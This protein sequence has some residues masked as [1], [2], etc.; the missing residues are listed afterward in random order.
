MEFRFDASQ[1]YQL[2][3]IEAVA[4]LLNGQPRHESTLALAAGTGLA[5]VANRFDL[6]EQRL[7]ENLQAVQSR[8][9]IPRSAT[10]ESIRERI[11]T[12]E[13]ESD[14]AFPNFSVEM[15]TGTGKTYVYLRTALELYQRYGLR[16]FIVVVPSVAVREGVLKTLQVTERHLREL[17]GN[18]PYRYYVYDSAQLA[19]VRQFALSDGVEIMIMT[20]DAFARAENVIRQSTD[21]LQGET[22]IHLVQLARPVLIL[23]EPQNMESERRVAALASLHPLF[24]LRYSATHRNAYN[25]VYRLTPAEAYRQGLVKRIQV[26]GVVQDD[27]PN[28]AFVR[29]DS[30]EL[31]RGAPKAGLTIHKLRADG[32]VAPASVTVQRE[33]KL[34]E[35]SGGRPQY[36]GYEVEEIN[37][38]SGYVRFANNVELRVGDVRGADREAV[39]D[40]QIRWTVAEHLRQQ[41]RLRDRGIKV[42]SLLFI[43]QVAS[44]ADEDGIVRTLF[45]RAFD[46]LKQPYEHWRGRDARDVRA[47]YFAEKRRRDGSVEL[48]D[49]T[50]G[51]NEQDR[52]AYDLIMKRKEQLLSFDEPAAFIFSHSALREGWDNPNVF[53]ICTLAQ[54]ASETKKRQE[55]GRGMRLAVDQTGSRVPDERVNVLT[56]VPN[57]SYRDYVSGLQD[58]I[59]E[60]YGDE[61]TPPPPPN[62]RERRPTVLRKG[63]T[64]RPEF[65]ELWQKISRRTRYRVRIDTERLLAEAVP[66]VERLDVRPPAVTVTL[67]ALQMDARSE[68]QAVQL[69][70]TRRVADLAPPQSVPNLVDIVLSLLERA[71]PPV[72]LTRRTIATLFG[73]IANK[74][75]ALANPHDF[76]AG[77]ARILRERL[78]EQ[79]VSGIQYEPVDEWYLMEQLEEQLEPLAEHVVPG[80]RSLYDLVECDSDVE[81]DFV[82]GLESRD[83]VKLYVKLPRWFTVDTPVGRYNPDWAIVME[84]RDVHGQPRGG[85]LLYLVRETKDT[86]Q[87]SQ[88]ETTE[89]QKVECGRAH[90][91]YALRVPFRVVKEAAELPFGGS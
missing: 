64:L 61:G 51:R 44:Y 31:R 62:A 65:R 39:F 10:L 59:R 40:A 21:R 23:D 9:G 89:R 80:E 41:E 72:R 13:G 88:L 71:S 11:F 14:V 70:G 81:R 38:G 49:S 83:D 54:T 17:Y 57:E 2:H 85:P 67:A 79:L 47:A 15:E 33:A 27:D 56:V 69:T 1:P 73:R 5:A 19:Q 48:L 16:K 35:K 91:E 90:F 22:P 82:H 6:T 53:Q 46:E 78:A 29:L 77:V 74:S 55:V 42:L 63:F 87:L 45:D 37:P 30:I 75:A 34:E 24:A 50:T 36:R 66:D 76:A 43:D 3:A 7:L 60:E 4:G 86:T 68:L 20:I 28:R 26:A 84:D 8:N 32:T 12:V 18:P 58:E 25:L 52:A